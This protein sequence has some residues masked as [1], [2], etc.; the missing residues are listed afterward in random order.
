VEDVGLGRLVLDDQQLFVRDGWARRLKVPRCDFGTGMTPS[1]V[2]DLSMCIDL[3][4]LVAYSD[5]V[6]ERTLEVVQ[7]LDAEDLDAIN[8]AAYVQRVV[9][10]DAFVTEDASW[11]P[12]Y[13][14]GQPKGFFLGHL[15]GWVTGPAGV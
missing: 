12:A 7:H 2:H 4:Q 11:V 10:E 13:M 15:G 5:A 6:V 14:N 1:E 3:E 8:D 9:D